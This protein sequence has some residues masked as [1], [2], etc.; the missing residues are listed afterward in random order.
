MIKVSPSLLSSSL[1]NLKEDLI[2]IKNAG[3]DFAHVDCM[4]GHFVPNIAFGPSFVSSLAK[5]N[6][7][8]LDVHLMIENPL[9]YIDSVIPNSKII[10]IHVETIDEDDFQEILERVHKKNKL[11]G[12]T[13]KPNTSINELDKYLSRVDL[14]L[15]MSVMPGFSGQKFMPSSYEMIKY[16]LNYRNKNNLNYIIEVDGG[17][18]ESN[19]KSL[20]DAGVDM[21]VS[22]NYLFSSNIEEK[23]KLMKEYKK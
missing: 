15:V 3:A 4:D 17:V 16:L 5:E 12:I 22:G 21:L 9:K 20:I 23:I 19:Y 2:R 8:D 18:N 7:I 11:L 6:I 13:L 1:T 10:T 14:V